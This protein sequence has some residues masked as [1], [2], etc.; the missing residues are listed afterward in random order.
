MIIEKIGEIEISSII[1]HDYKKSVIDIDIL[2]KKT[3]INYINL[4][5]DLGLVPSFDFSK[6][7]NKK[8]YTHEFIRTFM[9]FLKD[10]TKYPIYFFSS[11]STKD[12]FR[13]K[14]VEKMIKIFGAKIWQSH[15]SFSE[16]ISQLENKNASLVSNFILFLSEEK[17]IKFKKIKKNLQKEGLTFLNDVYFEEFSNKMSLSIR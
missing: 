4:V 3:N 9:E 16:F 15:E 1:L 12:K 6:K 10:N 2:F 7:N 5:S 11:S 13:N 8:L 17:N 14:L